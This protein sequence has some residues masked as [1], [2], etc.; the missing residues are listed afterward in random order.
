MTDARLGPAI[1]RIIARMPPRSA[2]VLRPHALG[3]YGTA[4][5]LRHYIRIARAKRHLVLT[6]GDGFAACDG[7]HLTRNSRNAHRSGGGAPGFRSMAVHDAKQA[8]LAQRHRVHAMLIS[9]IWSTTSHEGAG[10]IGLGA[11]SRHAARARCAVIALGG[12][13]Y[14]LA[15]SV[16]RHGAHGWAAIGAWQNIERNSY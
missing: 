4:A 6:S 14:P 3:A 9:P 10:P 8:L 12:V 7:I 2:I 1:P 5:Q 15:A 13:T 11:L 16:R